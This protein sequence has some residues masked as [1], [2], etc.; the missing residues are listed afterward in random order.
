MAGVLLV[1]VAAIAESGSDSSEHAKDR[2][3]A[4]ST[5]Q[6]NPGQFGE[7]SILGGSNFLTSEI[8]KAAQAHET[9]INEDLGPGTTPKIA[10]V[11]AKEAAPAH[12]AIAVHK[13]DR[14]WNALQEAGIP[15]DQ[16]MA[17]LDAAAKA[18]GLSY[19]WHGSG[20]HKWIKVNGHSDT[21]SVMNYLDKFIQR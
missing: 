15:A 11:P 10:K 8:A 13:G 18:S 1:G 20:T 14:P 3:I 9:K 12:E 19:E 4:G 5:L 21:K 17:R 7:G 6:D 2:V 16:I